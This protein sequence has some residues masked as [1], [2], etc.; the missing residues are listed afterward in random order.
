L[1]LIE[2][3]QPAD[4]LRGE[5]A[6]PS[7]VAVPGLR[8]VDWALAAGA[9]LLAGI[10]PLTSGDLIPS[11]L[12]G[13][14]VAGGVLAYRW[15][16]PRAE[17]ETRAFASGLSGWDVAGLAALLLGCT[18]VLWP[19]LGH[20][21]QRW[22]TNLWN[23][24]HGLFIPPAIA[25]LAW[26]AL[27]KLPEGRARGSAW[28]FPV[29]AAALVLVVL[30]T[31]SGLFLMATAGLVLMLPALALLLLG[32]RG[33]R[34]LLVP[35]AISPLMIPL[36]NAVASHMYLRQVTTSVVGPA[37][38]AL[39]FL[40]LR[41]GTVIQTPNQV[42]VIADACSGFSTLYASLSVAL[43]LAAMAGSLRLGLLLLAAAVP[44]ALAANA[45]RVLGL[46]VA[47][48]LFGTWVL[49]SPLHAASGVAT[50]FISLGGLFW[51]YGRRKEPREP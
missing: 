3:T 31:T 48:E 46:I 22:T 5:S 38:S 21:Y 34:A 4:D 9:G 47:T 24:G 39:G 40:N 43:I 14:V 7:A 23:N 12:A 19:T 28:G 51:I 37:F 45:L 15:H 44:L 6:P 33:T 8:A 18:L 42:F 25:Y 16:Q 13:A 36:P 35:L 32:T 11:A 17:A 10:S 20:L 27:Q 26:R 30:G 41:E 50:F 1:S 29:L 2:Q 49:D